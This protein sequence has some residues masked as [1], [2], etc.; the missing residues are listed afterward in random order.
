MDSNDG[1]LKDEPILIFALC[2]SPIEGQSNSPKP[3]AVQRNFQFI[4]LSPV[5][6]F[7]QISLPVIQEMEN[8]THSTTLG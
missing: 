2:A 6:V 7:R 4:F 1:G 3:S 5:V 8:V